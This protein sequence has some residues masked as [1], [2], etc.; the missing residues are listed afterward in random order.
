[1]FSIK[2]VNDFISD[3]VVWIDTHGYVDGGDNTYTIEKI[4]NLSVTIQPGGVSAR[5]V[6]PV[7]SVAGRWQM[8][9]EAECDTC[10]PKAVKEVVQEVAA[11]HD[12]MSRVARSLGTYGWRLSGIGTDGKYLT[13]ERDGGY[14]ICVHEDIIERS[15]Y[16]GGNGQ[17]LASMHLNNAGVLKSSKNVP[18]CRDRFQIADWLFSGYDF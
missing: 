16:I 10:T 18:E 8:V 15:V 2:R 6:L 11:K 3:V 5:A 1:M 13:A 9:F 7:F 17:S 12:V 14:D 4:D